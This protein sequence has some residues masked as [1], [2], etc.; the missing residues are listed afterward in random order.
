MFINS[1]GGVNPW[2]K[3]WWI[4]YVAPFVGAGIAATT[5]KILFA[6]EGDVGKENESFVTVPANEIK[7]SG[8]V[9]AGK[10]SLAANIYKN[11]F[12]EDEELDL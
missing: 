7:P 1:I 6:E 11:A 8:D 3:G 4:Y 9:E 10:E 12:A 2:Q 5:Y